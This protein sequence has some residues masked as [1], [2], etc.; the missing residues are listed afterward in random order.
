MLLKLGEC[1]LEE[2]NIFVDFFFLS[3]IKALALVRGFAGD[4]GREIA[5]EF[6]HFDEVSTWFPIFPTDFGKRVGSGIKEGKEKESFDMLFLKS[7]LRIVGSFFP[8]FVYLF[9]FI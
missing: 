5:E 8:I 2:I 7:N 1:C 6:C 3:F 9:D 4:L